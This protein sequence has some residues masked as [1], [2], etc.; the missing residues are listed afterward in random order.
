[1]VATPTADMVRVTFTIVSHDWY[2]NRAAIDKMQK[3][4]GTYVAENSDTKMHCT[5]WE[6]KQRSVYEALSWD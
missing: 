1:M 4:L 6:V 5:G 3:A 2:A